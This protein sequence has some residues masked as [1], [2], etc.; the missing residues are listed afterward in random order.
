MIKLKR[1]I[2]TD[3]WN[4]LD[5]D[6]HQMDM[7]II[8]SPFYNC[9]TFSIAY[10]IDIITS[11]NLKDYLHYIYTVT[12]K[13]QLIIDIKRDYELYIEKVFKP[14]RRVFKQQYVNSNSTN[15]TIY[16]LRVDTLKDD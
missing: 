7:K 9:Q 15:M 3:N 12:G 16:L 5:G 13:P 8:Q 10:I 1:A 6:D 4:V 14:E 11:P 2:D